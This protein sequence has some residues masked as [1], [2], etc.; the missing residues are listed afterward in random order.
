MRTLV[1]RGL[2][3]FALLMIAPLVLTSSARAQVNPLWDHYKVYLT[4][5]F[6]VPPLG[7]PV[8]LTDQFGPFNH[9]VQ[10]L[11]RIMNPTEKR[12]GPAIFPIHNPDLHYTWWSISPQPF[13]A[14]VTATNQ[15]GDFTINIHDAVYLLNP[16]RKN[17][18][19]GPPSGNHYKCYFCDGPPVNIPI[20]MIDQFGPW[21]ANVTFPRYWCNPVE[22]QVP[23]LPPN[24]ILDPNQHYICYEFQPPD[25]STHTATV[26][27]QFIVNHTTEMVPAQY[28]CVPTY[29]SGVTGTGTG[30]WGK[31]KVLYR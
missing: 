12:V 9:T 28:I 26:T 23:G 11:E 17:Q 29:K 21:S 1:P 5:P 7:T 20:T 18:P 15:F 8:I 13:N 22:K 3:W 6:P 27:D 19:G 4:P 16:A 14:S 2:F 25:Q 24:L 31:L 10:Q 30:T